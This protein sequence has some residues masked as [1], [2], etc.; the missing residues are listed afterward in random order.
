[1]NIISPVIADTFEC[2]GSECPDTCCAGWGITIDPK[3]AKYY[4]SVPGEFGDRLRE[5]TKEVGHKRFFTLNE[6]GRCPFLNDRNLCS[7]YLTLG[8][9]KMG[10]TC[11]VFPRHTFVMDD[12]LLNYLSFACPETI[13]LYFS[14]E[15]SM[16]F[17]TSVTNELKNTGTKMRP[18]EYNTF[19]HTL[20]TGIELLQNR[21]LS[22][23]ERLIV[24]I[25][26]IYS[27]QANLDQDAGDRAT[28]SLFSDPKVY[29]QILNDDNIP[30]MDVAF[31]IKMFR[32]LCES[33]FSGN[34]KDHKLLKIYKEFNQYF[35]GKD[36][37][38]LSSEL[39]GSMDSM[40]NKEIDREMEHLLVYL[41]FRYILSDYTKKDLTRPLGN[42]IAFYTTY[43]CFLAVEMMMNS[44]KI[45]MDRRILILSRLSRYYEHN[46]NTFSEVHSL[47]EQHNMSDVFSLMRVV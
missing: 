43:L 39:C 10:Y 13:R 11:K 25:S 8:P 1:M 12:L 44:K 33:F 47:M 17:L 9:D 28:I 35:Q 23:R 32:L 40:K 26:F 20:I 37:R 31:R 19:L 45:D 36:I 5:Y 38:E 21:D 24:F 7:V 18:E 16:T 27:Q 46:A 6:E 22:I 29:S 15:E 41:C 42:M 4:D 14:D 34:C 30:D 3:T 2:V